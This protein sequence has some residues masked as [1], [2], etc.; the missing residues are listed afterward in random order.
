VLALPYEY[1][2]QF[3]NKV[4]KIL[5]LKKSGG[6]TSKLEKEIDDMVYKL[7]NLTTEEYRNHRG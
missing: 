2:K 3:I 1:K 6:D 7:Y 4:D 5:E